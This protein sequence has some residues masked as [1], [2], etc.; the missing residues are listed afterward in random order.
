VGKGDYFTIGGEVQTE[1]DYDRQV[2]SRFSGHYR[3]AWGEALKIVKGYPRST[4]LS[5]TE[6]FQQV[7][8]PVRDELSR[9]WTESAASS[10]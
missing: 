9:K 8:K 6:F 5:Q 4:L 2:A 3:D 1:E 10:S 7:Y